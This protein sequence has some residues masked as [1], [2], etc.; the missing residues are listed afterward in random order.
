MHFLFL[1]IALPVIAGAL[2]TSTQLLY[3]KAYRR[4][5]R[6][7]QRQHHHVVR[8][9][10]VCDFFTT[11]QLNCSIEEFCAIL[12]DAEDVSTYEC[13]GDLEGA[14]T[15]YYRVEDPLKCY[16]SF[17]DENG[18]IVED[19][20]LEGAAYCSR[21]TGYFNFTG[22]L[23]TVSDLTEEITA[24]DELQGVLRL[25]LPIAAC[26]M[27]ESDFFINQPYCIGKCPDVIE[28]NGVQ[29]E[30]DCVECDD[31]SRL[32]NCGNIDAS[33]VGNCAAPE[34]ED[35][36]FTE[37]FLAYFNKTNTGSSAGAQVSSIGV[38]LSLLAFF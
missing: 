18:T 7:L 26:T 13:G 19:V 32:P 23:L 11:L 28:I 29:C 6:L 27:D 9:L 37:E 4:H 30:G 25:V 38:L 8:K 2:D 33:L 31:G 14:G 3:D 15:F 36:D 20:A 21:T 35:D 22:D 1:V 17:Q 16:E 10:E 12:N 5:T 34:W 24:P